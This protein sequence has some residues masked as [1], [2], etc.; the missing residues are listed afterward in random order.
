MRK[1]RTMFRITLSIIMAAGEGMVTAYDRTL[2]IQYGGQTEITKTWLH[3]LL[4]GMGYVKHK[5]MTKCKPGISSEELERFKEDFLMQITEMESIPDRLIVN[6]EQTGI[7][8]VPVGDW[9]MG[10][11]GSRREELVGL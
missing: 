2:L 7:C 5:A 9:T 6:L 4:R 3:H 8:L 1:G 11:E 10:A